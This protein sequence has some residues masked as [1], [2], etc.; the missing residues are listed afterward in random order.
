MRKEANEGQG[1]PAEQSDFKGETG[2]SI[3]FDSGN[4]SLFLREISYWLDRKVL[5]R[6]SEQPGKQ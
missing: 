4:E 2:E 1:H 5:K 3:G 6:N